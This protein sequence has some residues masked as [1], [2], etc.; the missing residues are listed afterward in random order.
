MRNI[1]IQKIAESYLIRG[2]CLSSI[3]GTDRRGFY[4]QE[5]IM[6]INKMM[7]EVIPVL[8]VDVYLMKNNTLTLTDGR[9]SW[10]CDRLN[11]E[12]FSHF[13][14]RSCNGVINYIKNY[15]PKKTL[16]LFLI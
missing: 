5:A 16:S 3:T 12:D 10:Y 6:L 14:Q 13:A 8:G 2:A 4:Q 1:D 11:N 9:D 15:T 7:E